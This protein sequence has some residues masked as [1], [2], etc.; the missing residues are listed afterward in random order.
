MGAHGFLV[1]IRLGAGVAGAG[2]EVL[3]ELGGRD[4]VGDLGERGQN[5]AGSSAATPCGSNTH[6]GPGGLEHRRNDYLPV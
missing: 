3:G 2:G 6:T 4:L 5:Q 1:G